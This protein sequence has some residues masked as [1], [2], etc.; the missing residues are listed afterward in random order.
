MENLLAHHQLVRDVTTLD[1]VLDDGTADLNTPRVIMAAVLVRDHL[2][3][4]G[5]V[6]RLAHEQQLNAEVIFRGKAA[7]QR[8]CVI[9]T[10]IA[11]HPRMVAPDDEVCAAQIPADDGMEHR[12]PRPA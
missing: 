6:V 2:P 11:A 12:F 8:M 9:R 10:V 7:G 5:A 3:A 4:D 1:R